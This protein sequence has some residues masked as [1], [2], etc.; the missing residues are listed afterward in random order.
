MDLVFC[1]DLFIVADLFGT[2]ER[3]GQNERGDLLNLLVA[4]RP[5]S[6]T[7]DRLREIT[8]KYVHFCEIAG[9][10]NLVIQL[11]TR[12]PD[13]QVCR[14][15]FTQRHNEDLIV[16]SFDL[17][18]ISVGDGEVRDGLTEIYDGEVV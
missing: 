5:F 1:R 9:R 10:I 11:P 17:K 7:G 2:D 6:Y 13:E 14:D 16:V 3:L 12:G 4:R 18:R 15:A 8:N